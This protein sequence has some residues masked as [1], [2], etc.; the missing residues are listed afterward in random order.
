MLNDQKYI[1][2][3]DVDDA[4][5]LAAR[6]LD[7]L[8]HDFSTIESDWQPTSVVLAGMGGSALAAMYVT[9]LWPDLKIPF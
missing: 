5:G 2:R 9:A 6:Q 3:F 7:Q 8:R 1:A 4:L